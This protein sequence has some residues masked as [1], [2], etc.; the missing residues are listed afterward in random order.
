MDSCILYAC[1]SICDV[2]NMAGMKKNPFEG[3]PWKS[4]EEYHELAIKHGLWGKEL[5]DH[6]VDVNK[7]TYSLEPKI[8][9]KK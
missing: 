9:E 8:K 6:I 1:L 5:K 2:C 3:V 7:K 4:V